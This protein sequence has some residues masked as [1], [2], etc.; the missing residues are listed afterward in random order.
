MHQGYMTSLSIV[1]KI[2]QKHGLDDKRPTLLH[3]YTSLDA[4]LSIIQQ[5]R[6]LVMSL[7]VSQRRFGNNESSISYKRANII[8]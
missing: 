7:R 3:H 5:R 1:D 8:C 4:A 6:Y 2:T